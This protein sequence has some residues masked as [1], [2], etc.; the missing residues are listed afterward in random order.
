M[1][2]N[3]L[4]EHWTQL[5]GDLTARRCFSWLADGGDEAGTTL[6]PPPADTAAAVDARLSPN[7]T[8]A[9]ELQKVPQCLGNIHICKMG[10][11]LACSGLC[12]C[13][14]CV[15]VRKLGQRVLPLHRHLMVSGV[16]CWSA[17][18]PACAP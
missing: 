7:P 2:V 1:A 18:S 15:L 13:S 9:A 16:V 3:L 4:V 8:L 11:L 10:H 17:S 5:L 6:E 12:L 14:L